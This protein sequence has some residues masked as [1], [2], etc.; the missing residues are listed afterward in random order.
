MR[1]IIVLSRHLGIGFTIKGSH[2]AYF[3]I[4]RNCESETV[5][6]DAYFVDMQAFKAP[7]NRSIV[8]EFAVIKLK[9]PNQAKCLMFKAP[10]AQSLLP[11]EYQTINA[12]CTRNHHGMR[13]TDGDIEYN[14]LHSIICS[15]LAGASQIFVKGLEKKHWLEEII[16]RAV[17]NLEDYDCPALYK[18]SS[19]P[20]T[21]HPHRKNVFNVY[22]CAYENVQKLRCWYLENVRINHEN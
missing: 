10:F 16:V 18:L 11:P 4:R 17:T 21:R 19:L 2:N 12:W 13:W 8:K 9:N 14:Q 15:L 6:M 3:L 5:I 20:H 7:K 1:Y 22:R